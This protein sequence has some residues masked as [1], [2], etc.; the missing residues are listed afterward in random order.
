MALVQPA[1]QYAVQKLDSGSDGVDGIS[2][3][4]KSRHLSCCEAVW[5]LLGFKIHGKFPAVESLFVHLPGMNF[6]AMHDGDDSQEVTDDPDSQK[7][8]LTECYSKSVLFSWSSLD[9]L[10]ISII[11]MRG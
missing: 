6:V 3:Y 7:S 9:L 5:R 2:E 11:Y 4:I 10:P 1:T 8:M